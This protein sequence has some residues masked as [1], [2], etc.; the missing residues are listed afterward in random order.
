MGNCTGRLLLVQ[1]SGLSSGFMKLLT[2]V[3]VFPLIVR[4]FKHPK[5]S[6]ELKCLHDLDV[7]Y[8]ELLSD[9]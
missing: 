7:Y 9:L 5:R 8:S 1:G 6:Q 3:L 2:E 4:G